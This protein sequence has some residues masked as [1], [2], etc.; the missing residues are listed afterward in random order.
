[1]QFDIHFSPP[2][3]MGLISLKIFFCFASVMLQRWYLGAMRVQGRWARQWTSPRT[4]R[5]KWRSS[6][7]LTSSI[8]WP[9]TW[10]H[11]TGACRTWGWMGALAWVSSRCKLWIT[12]LTLQHLHTHTSTFPTDQHNTVLTLLLRRLQTLVP[13]IPI[14]HWKG[15]WSHHQKTD[16]LADSLCFF[17]SISRGFHSLMCADIYAGFTRNC[18]SFQTN[19]FNGS[20]RQQGFFLLS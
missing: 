6:L 9:V 12:L 8:W 14:T 10:L 18:S 11:W 19:V 1:M 17:F 7:R 2:F 13:L 5:R 4:T 3:I 16:I 20:G 15:L